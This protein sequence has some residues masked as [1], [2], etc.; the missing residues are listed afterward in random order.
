MKKFHFFLF[1][2]ALTCFMVGCRKPVEVSF[3]VQSLNVA[4]EGGNYTVE[5]K[6]NGEWNIGS[7]SDWLTVSPT[8][9]NGNATLTIVA[10][11]NTTLRARCIEIQ[12]SSK[13]NTAKLTVSQ[14]GRI[15]PIISLDPSSIECGVEG[16]EFS[17]AVHTQMAWTVSSLPVWITCSTM[18]GEGEATVMVKV[19]P[20]Q[21]GAR[22]EADVVFG[23]ENASARL[24]VI[25]K[26]GPDHYLTLTPNSLQIACTGESKTVAVECD[27]AWFLTCDADWIAF[28]KT[29]SMVG[30][31]VVVTV[32]ENPIYESRSAEVL[33]RTASN[34]SAVL[35]VTQEATPNPHYLNVDLNE[36]NYGKEGGSLDVAVECDRSWRVFCDA[37]WLTASMTTGTGNEIVTFTASP[38]VFYENRTA[39]VRI[40]SGAYAQFISVTQ[41]PGDV[42]CW[43]SVTPDS[44]FVAQVG[45]VKSISVTSNCGW[46]VTKPEWITMPVVSDTCDATLDMMVDVNVQPTSRVGYITIQRGSE[47]LANVVVVQEGISTV[48]STDVTE[49]NLP[50][51][52]GFEYFSL[53]SNLSWSIRNPVTWLECNPMEGTGDQMILVKAGPLETS[54]PREA[55]VVIKNSLGATLSVTV[56]QSN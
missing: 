44:L 43:A 1:V 21:E 20:L 6:S 54:E 19:M 23:D 30:E 7:T 48:F 16:G 29:E 25:Q 49:I 40:S 41:E 28:D 4:A 46:T 53:T 35:V 52:G 9:G 39:T 8:S 18:E 2:A 5:L 10:Q 22:R 24:H 56:R 32:S 13:D 12:A 42:H 38:N 31:E 3:G 14:E 15:E 47:V 33:F 45:G 34:N 17:I 26:L 36:L 51:E 11:P 55:V 27:E 37:Y 50:A